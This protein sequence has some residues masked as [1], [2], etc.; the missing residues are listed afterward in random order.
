[1]QTRAPRALLQLAARIAVGV[2]ASGALLHALSTVQASPDAGPRTAPTNADLPVAS[3][4][5]IFH[6]EKNENQNQVHYTVQ[7]DPAC[8]PVGAKPLYGYWRE[9]TKGPNAVSSLLDREQPA[10]GLNTPR[11][12]RPTPNGGQISV[13]LR[14]FPKRPLI[15]DVFKRGQACGAR[16]YVLIQKQTA[17]LTSIYV[18]VGFFFRVNYA[19][20]RGIRTSDGQPV[21]EKI[22]PGK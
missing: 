20:V 2:L 13:S 4:Q 8:H 14:A 12:V 9:L 18:D 5:S 1:M 22:Q 21:E 16:A 6:I 19:L 17:V 15:I 3:A 10:Y 7:T 11:Y